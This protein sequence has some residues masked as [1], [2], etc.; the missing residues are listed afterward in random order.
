[1]ILDIF[2]KQMNERILL[3]DIPSKPSALC[4]EPP[5]AHHIHQLPLG[6]MPWDSFERL[7]V[8]LAKTNPDIRRFVEKLI[9]ITK[10]WPGFAKTCGAELVQLL[11][12][13]SANELQSYSELLLI[14]RSR[15]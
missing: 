5:D 10:H 3:T 6:R 2:G 13:V 11:N 9:E 15:A 14:L 1:L 7:C 4:T 8:R 12:R